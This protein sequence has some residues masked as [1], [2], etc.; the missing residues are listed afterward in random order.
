[1]IARFPA[2]A[3]ICSV[4]LWALTANAQVSIGEGS[5]DTMPLAEGEEFAE[6]EPAISTSQNA[7]GASPLMATVQLNMG[8][9]QLRGM[10]L[11]ATE[12]TVSTSFGDANVPLVE[13]AGIKLASEANPTTTI[14]MHNGDSI[15]GGLN[16]ERVRL[17]TEWGLADIEGA[18]I[19]SIVFADG[20]TWTMK[21]GRAG[22]RWELNSK[23]AASPFK[24]GDAVIAKQ[25]SDLR[26]GQNVVG[27]VR[28]NEVL[29][30]QAVEGQFIL[31]KTRNSGA[32]W[33]DSTHASAQSK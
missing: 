23:T 6:S 29:T 33:L 13:V 32:G 7:D 1:M 12:I 16:L 18:A 25:N 21:D 30:V 10:L 24:P 5:A 31:V 2:L 19:N 27:T 4:A 28:R 17:Q 11:S 26:F 20:L 22:A 8:N 3:V 15:T 14:A 9:T